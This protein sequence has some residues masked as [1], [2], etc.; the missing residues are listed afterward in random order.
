M[1]ISPSLFSEVIDTKG[2]SKRPAFSLYV[3]RMG[4]ACCVAAKDRTIVHGPSS[5]T[6]QR[7]VRYSPSWSFRWDNR[8]RVA[9]EETHANWLHHGDVRNDQVEVKYSN[10]VENAFALEEGS[11]LHGRRSRWQKSPISDRSAGNSKLQVSGKLLRALS[12]NYFLDI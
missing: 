4:A 9:G 5:G 12:T 1:A 3:R 11:P 2:Y 6:L 7:H 8:G 10:T